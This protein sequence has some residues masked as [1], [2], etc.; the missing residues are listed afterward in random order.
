MKRLISAL[1]IALSF[2]N[3]PS[4]AA[5]HKP[6]I[7]VIWTDDQGYA[8]LSVHG[9]KDFQT[10][11]IDSLALNGVRCTDGYVTQ[12]Q[13]SPSRAGM[14]TGRHQ[15]R[16]GPGRD[17][18]EVSLITIEGLGHNWAGGVSQAPEFLVGKNTDKLKAA[19]VVWEFF[20][21]HPRKP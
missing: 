16:F 14:I 3:A 5:G 20:Q 4:H 6:N 12:P 18:A 17:G 2:L 10:P 7:I 13:C 9:N 8:D 1:I 11:H 19:D 21:Q 15:S